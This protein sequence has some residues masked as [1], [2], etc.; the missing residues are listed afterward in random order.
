MFV[1]PLSVI[2]IEEHV[3]DVLHGVISGVTGVWFLRHIK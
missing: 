3:G 1:P 2:Y